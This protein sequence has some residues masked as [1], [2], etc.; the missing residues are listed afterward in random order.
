MKELAGLTNL[1]ELDLFGTKVTDA[2]LKH[3]APLKGLTHLH[4]VG[5]QVTD[6]TL[7]TLQEPGLLHTLS[8]AT[9]RD[10]K[11]PT[12][13]DDVIAINLTGAKVTGDGL[14][15]LA[16]FKNL[17]SLTLTPFEVNDQVLAA[18]REAN[19]LHA[20]VMARAADG[21][22]P[23]KPADVVSLNLAL[24]KVSDVGLK[25]LAGLE[26]LAELNLFGSKVTGAGVKA[27]QKVL[28][29]CKIVE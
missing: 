20:L 13:P 26:N 24:S 21:N 25:E 22:R 28:P 29:K 9:A 6:Q 8:L 16:G 1:T 7:T 27:L 4:L 14:K 10:G 5:S 11:R 2:G 18:L 15:V 23:A 12:K 3:L 19:P 17:T